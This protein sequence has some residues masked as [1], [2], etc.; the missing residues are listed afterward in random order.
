MIYDVI[1]G[2]QSYVGSKYAKGSGWYHSGGH[3]GKY[4]D[5]EYYDCNVTVSCDYSLIKEQKNLIATGEDKIDLKGNDGG[6][7]IIGNKS[8]NEIEG[9]K[10]DDV[11]DGKG[12][13]DKIEGGDG[14]DEI[15]GGDG[16]DTLG[17]GDGCDTIDGGEDADNISGGDKADKLDGGDG[18]DKINGDEG[19]DEI[20]GGSGCDTLDG[21]EGCDTLYGGDDN[22]ILIGGGGGDTLYGGNGDDKI[23]GS[24]EADCLDGGAG[25]DLLDGGYG[26]D[27]LNGGE[28]ADTY[29]F[30]ACYGEETIIDCG[31]PSETD[32]V[33]FKTDISLSDVCFSI[34][35]S[36]LLV[37]TGR[38]GDTITVKDW[39]ESNQNQIEQFTFASEE[40]TVLTNAQ[41]NDSLTDGC[42]TI[43]A[44]DLVGS[45]QEQAAAAS[46]Q[47]AA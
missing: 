2:K 36:D 21:G 16:C 15:Y 24:D 17:G 32:V 9:G 27:V 4:S 23:Y 18:D 5:Y 26:N 7:V 45:V 38:E 14:N 40:G 28:G 33:G 46:A 20:H 44:T 30:G 3:E 39:F 19:N 12:G 8:D 22:D 6:N 1:Y 34:S 42:T 11:L 43:C 31:D 25:C 41:I 35:G 37:T 29:V 13:N 47:I 10:G